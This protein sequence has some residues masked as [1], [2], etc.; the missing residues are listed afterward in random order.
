MYFMRV[1]YRGYNTY[2]DSDEEILPLLAIKH[3][4]RG[5]SSMGNPTFAARAGRPHEASIRVSLMSPPSI[6]ELAGLL[7]ED[8]NITRSVV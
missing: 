3:I 6:V 8:Q 1:M 2:L 7:G 5:D 4:N